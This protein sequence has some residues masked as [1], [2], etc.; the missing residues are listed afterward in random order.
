MKTVIY[1]IVMVCL[2]SQAA[3]A[4]NDTSAVSVARE[5]L[6]NFKKSISRENYKQFNFSSFEEGQNSTLGEE[7]TNQYI[8]LDELKSF[9]EGNSPDQLIKST[10][11]KIVALNNSNQDVVGSVELEKT[12]GKWTMKSIGRSTV[13]SDYVRFTRQGSG[14]GW[15][16][17]RVLALNRNF[18]AH[19]VQNQWMVTLLGNV[20]LGDI[21]PGV[22]ESLTKVMPELQKEANTY[23]GLPW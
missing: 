16:L 11:R 13:I 22:E 7:V 4:Q 23:N 18:A 21:R 20:P 12:K 19:K 3:I 10:G 9:K 17:L 1:L 6:T 14:G 8:R 2:I 5:S 15:V